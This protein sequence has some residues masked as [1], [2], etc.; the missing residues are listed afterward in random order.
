M[1]ELIEAAINT[2]CSFP[3]PLQVA[4]VLFSVMFVGGFVDEFRRRGA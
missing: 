1:T 4:L 3:M 2:V